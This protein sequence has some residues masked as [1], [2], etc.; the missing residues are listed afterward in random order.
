MRHFYKHVLSGI[1]FWLLLSQS[2]SLFNSSS[3]AS[4]SRTSS[5]TSEVAETEDEAELSKEMAVTPKE[6]EE[7]DDKE[8]EGSEGRDF[9]ELLKIVKR[10]ISDGE[11][12]RSSSGIFNTT[13]AFTIPLFSFSL[14]DRATAG[15]DYTKQAALSLFG[16]AIVGGIAIM[17]YVWAARSPLGKKTVVESS[18]AKKDEIS[19]S[20]LPMIAN[21]A[22]LAGLDAKTCVQ[23]SVCETY[24]NPE[25]YGYLVFP[26]R[27]FMLSPQSREDDKPSEYQRAAEFGRQEKEECER[28]YRCAFSLIGAANFLFSYFLPPSTA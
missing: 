6:V 15:K 20:I 3:A 22:S 26:V 19:S 21:V 5:Y 28:R 25:R 16:L 18:R 12:G 9:S 1:V 4:T 7:A 11:T 14:P 10:E 2:L 27:Y 23:R 17:P 13:L 24:R 8:D